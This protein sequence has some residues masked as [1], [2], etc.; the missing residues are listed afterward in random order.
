MP[1]QQVGGVLPRIFPLLTAVYYGLSRGG[2]YGICMC[3]ICGELV[4]H[5]HW[6][7]RVPWLAGDIVESG[8]ELAR[9][10]RR[11][12]MRRAE[13]VNKLLSYYGLMFADWQGGKYL[14]SDRKGQSVIV[15]DLAGLWTWVE[16]I[17]GRPLDPL[18]ETLLNYL[19]MVGQI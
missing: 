13:I 11:L 16:R 15:N 18:D 5:V 17:L 7:E 12:R 2:V 14:L 1:L 19:T 4:S 10:T 8:G 3:G 9:V 6:A